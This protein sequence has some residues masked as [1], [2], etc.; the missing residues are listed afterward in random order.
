MKVLPRLLHRLTELEQARIVRELPAPI[1]EIA[2]KLGLTKE[3]R[4]SSQPAS[5]LLSR[6]GFVA[7]LAGLLLA[8]WFGQVVIVVLLGLVLSAA[9]LAKLWSR[10]S[11]AGVSCQRTLSEQ[12]VFP[13]EHIELRLRMVNRKLL[14]LPWIQMDD[15]IP[16]QFSSEIPFAASNSPGLGFLSKSAALLWY[17][18]VSWKQRLSCRKRGYYQLGPITL[19]AGDIFGFYP[20]SVT[21]PVVDHVI[22][23][24]KI[25]P[26]EH[27]GIPSLHPL[28]ETIAEWRIF[29]DPVR[30]I[31][32]RDYNPRDSRRHI[33]WKATAR[34]QELQVKVFEPTT[35]LK[36]A[37][38]LAVDSFKSQPGEVDTEEDFE[39]G[40]STAASIASYLTERRSAV[41]LFAN[42]CLA[43][44]GQPAALLPASSNG[45]LVDIL[46][47][48][49]KV[50]SSASSPFEEF[51]QAERAA[52]PWGTTLV[53][54]LY[55]PS[56]FLTELLIGL[57]ESGHK[58]LVFQIG[59]NTEGSEIPGVIGC[60]R[61]RQPGDLARVGTEE[62]G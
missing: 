31:G 51:L 57:K 11:L 45:Q 16:L 30:V 42:S 24:P 5:Y 9:G 27:L 10:F 13:G 40:I 54:I 1:E 33:H 50:T 32:V 23:Y 47:T 3:T 12:R 15:E 20:R 39:L 38:F 61:I 14:P 59:D 8:A 46:E 43:D 7:L 53:F 19:T 28:G 48:L 34:R 62:T 26:I 36:V 60:H 4:F 35:T 41:G 25:F 2:N 37:I 55:R 21:Q 17:T 52:L 56:Q 49:A 58:L 22:V 18:G 44:S 29:E 6:L